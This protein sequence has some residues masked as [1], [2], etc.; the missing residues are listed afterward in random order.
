MSLLFPTLPEDDGKKI[1]K[2]RNAAA[3]EARVVEEP[4]MQIPA[5]P[6]TI[7]G[8]VEGDIQ[9]ADS[10]CCSTHHDI[11]DSERGQW[12]LECWFCGTGQWIEA[13]DG[14][15]EERQQESPANPFEWPQDGSRFAGKP[16][17]GLPPQVIAWAAENDSSEDTRKACQTWIASRGGTV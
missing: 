4:A 3:P 8:R 10:A 17:S 5:S 2:S 12:L 7:I 6:R 14:R 9:C 11:I 13:I 16:F 1:R 15:L